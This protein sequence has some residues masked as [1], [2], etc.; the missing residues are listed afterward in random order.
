M[1]LVDLVM[2]PSF[3]PTVWSGFSACG[4]RHTPS[5]LCVC[6]NPFSSKGLSLGVNLL[7]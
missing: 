2:F 1:V 5:G 6:V 3:V 7:A 4:F